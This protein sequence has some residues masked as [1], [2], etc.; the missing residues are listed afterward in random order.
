[1]RRSNDNALLIDTA[2]L[3]G[4]IPKEGTLAERLSAALRL[5]LLPGGP[6]VFGGTDDERIV[7]AVAALVAELG[8][9]SEDGRRISA[10]MRA[11]RALSAGNFIEIQT[12]MEEIG[13][14]DNVIGIIKIAGDVLRERDG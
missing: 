9:A 10:E 8:P 6:T 14:P 11:L 3:R 4:R 13:G 12:A 2:V 5:S 1:M 7:T